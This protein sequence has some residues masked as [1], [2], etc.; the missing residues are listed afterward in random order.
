MPDEFKPIAYLKNGCPFSFKL[1]LAILELGIL[2]Q[3]IIRTFSGGTSDEISV[4]QELSEK[5]AKITFPIVE[6]SPGRFMRESDDLIAYFAKKQ[7]KEVFEL[8]TL[9]A[10]VDG[11]FKKLMQLSR[12]NKELKRAAS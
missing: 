1:R 11:P 4:K 8:P 3:F 6:I 9:T 2:D 12:E 7:R 5:V 10:Y